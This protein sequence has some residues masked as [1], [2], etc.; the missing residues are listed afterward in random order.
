LGLVAIG[1]T[2]AGQKRKARKR[3]ITDSSRLAAALRTDGPAVMRDGEL[4]G[5]LIETFVLA[6]IRPEVEMSSQSR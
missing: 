3:Y 5:R 1:L 6:Q 2:L 4:L